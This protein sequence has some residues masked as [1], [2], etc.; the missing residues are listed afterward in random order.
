MLNPILKAVQ[1]VYTKP[2]KTFV[3]GPEG[4]MGGT[5]FFAP[6]S[7]QTVRARA[8]VCVC[9]CPGVGGRSVPTSQRVPPPTASPTH[10]FPLPH[11]SHTSCH[12]P[13][14]VVDR[15]RSEYTGPANL[16]IA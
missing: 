3:F 10:A 13:P 11:P 6:A 2:G 15:I 4:E 12:A 8:C 7:Y 16:K 14:Q 5:I 9:V 1:E